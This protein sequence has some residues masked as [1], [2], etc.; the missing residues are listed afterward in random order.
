[1]S[2]RDHRLFITAKD[3]P[4][5]ATQVGTRWCDTKVGFVSVILF[6]MSGGGCRLTGLATNRCTREDTKQTA[7]PKSQTNQSTA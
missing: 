1:M 3:R 6:V 2:R 7:I 4:V 5:F